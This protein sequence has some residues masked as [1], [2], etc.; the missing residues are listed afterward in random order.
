MDRGPCSFQKQNWKRVFFPV[1][2]VKLGNGSARRHLGGKRQ[3]GKSS[4]AKACPQH[5]TSC[6]AEQYQMFCSSDPTPVPRQGRRNQSSH[7]PRIVPRPMRPGRCA[8]PPARR[9]ALSSP[10]RLQHRCLARDLSRQLWSLSFCCRHII[11]RVRVSTLI[12]IRL[13][14]R[15][16]CILHC[17]H[18]QQHPKPQSK[19]A[20]P[21]TAFTSG[22]L[23]CW[24]RSAGGRLGLGLSSVD[25]KTA[26][27]MVFQ[28][29][30]VE[31]A[32]APFRALLRTNCVI[33]LP[34]SALR[35]QMSQPSVPVAFTLC[36]CSPCSAHGTSGAR[37]TPCACT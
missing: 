20:V 29:S 10:G 4:V 12:R 6:D 7:T 30:A 21:L 17:Q 11:R 5:I 22:Q 18:L 27:K 3:R 28:P 13:A 15:S 24:G 8:Q 36:S 35:Q 19:L 9:L 25:S 14:T 2:S 16:L 1:K 32:S 31:Q 37:L 34:F 33:L 23:L 26:E